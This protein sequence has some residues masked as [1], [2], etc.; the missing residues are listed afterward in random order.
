M[1][2]VTQNADVFAE[3]SGLLKAAAVNLNKIANDLR[4]LSSGP[5]T[6]FGEINLPE[7]QAAP[8]SCR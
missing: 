2:D 1:L 7:I 3:V 6:G 5:F 4:L 8:A